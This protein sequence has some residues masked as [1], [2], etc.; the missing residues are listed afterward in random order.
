MTARDKAVALAQH[1]LVD[2]HQRG[3]IS[4]TD[5]ARAEV[6]SLVDLIIE[7]AVTQAADTVT[8]AWELASKKAADDL[9]LVHVKKFPRPMHRFH[10][11]DHSVQL[12]I[13]HV[14]NAIASLQPR[15][16]EGHAR[17]H[18]VLVSTLKTLREGT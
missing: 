5:G 4:N 3:G 17:I 15:S 14:V 11:L 9:A 18:R 1:Y 2:L 7:A 10:E 13:G 8:Q 6:V 16:P 12:A